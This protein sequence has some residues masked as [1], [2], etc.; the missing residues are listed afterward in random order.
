[1]AEDV[2]D[3]AIA[4]RLEVAEAEVR[5]LRYELAEVKRE[6]EAERL[7][8]AFERV[9]LEATI[10]NEHT[11]YAEAV[12]ELEVERQASLAWQAALELETEAH[13]ATSRQVDALVELQSRYGIGAPPL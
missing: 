2:T 3:Y 5:R 13:E 8:R 9:D 11:L 6:L 7:T 10:W 1:M 12:A 4:A